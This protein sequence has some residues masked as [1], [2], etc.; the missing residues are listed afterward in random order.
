M[1]RFHLLIPAVL[2]CVVSAGAAAQATDE[3]PPDAADVAGQ[4]AGAS[5]DGVRAADL[6]RRAIRLIRDRDWKRAEAALNEALAL[7]PDTPINLY[8]L[9]CVRAQLGRADAA[10]EALERAAAAVEKAR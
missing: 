1:T 6:T 10:I 9:A 4:L 7:A 2:A 3:A 8:N 5:P